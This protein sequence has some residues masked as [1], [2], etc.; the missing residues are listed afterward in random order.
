MK[1]LIVLSLILVLF[2]IGISAAQPVFVIDTSDAVEVYR[3]TFDD[4]SA[5]NDFTQYSGT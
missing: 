3:N 4:A 2:T 1:K 5:L